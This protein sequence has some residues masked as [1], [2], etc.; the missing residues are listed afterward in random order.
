M[1]VDKEKLKKKLLRELNHDYKERCPLCNEVISLD[2]IIN[3]KFEYTKSAFGE[4]Y[5]HT[6]CIK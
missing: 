3:C 6:K 1:V 2:D 5:I 4:R